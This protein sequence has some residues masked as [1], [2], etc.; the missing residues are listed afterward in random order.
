MSETTSPLSGIVT[1]EQRQFL[2]ELRESATI[3]MFAA[4][5]NLMR[6]FGLSKQDAKLVLLA[7]MK[8]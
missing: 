4:A 1:P 3:N 2:E 6:R 7:W 8:S 5:P